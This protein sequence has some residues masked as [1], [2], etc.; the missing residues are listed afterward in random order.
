MRGH[1]T[2]HTF[3]TPAADAH[4]SEVRV[5]LNVIR[6]VVRRWRLVVVDDSIVRGTTCRARIASLREQ[7]ARQVH[8]RVS[9]APIRQP[10]YCGV[11]FQH[12][13]ELIAAERE[14]DKVAE[15]IGAD[16][17][18]CFTGDYPVPAEKGMG[19]HALEPRRR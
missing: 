11:D 18:A 2:G 16:R 7:G 13:G 8:L 6:D 17:L 14:A 12:P 10:C 5:K 15:P 1:Y 9:A 3:S 4:V 19:K